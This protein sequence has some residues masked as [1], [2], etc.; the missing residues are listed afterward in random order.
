MLNIEI[1]EI[2][3]KMQRRLMKLLIKERILARC[4]IY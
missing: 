2:L 1:A 3:L 4:Q